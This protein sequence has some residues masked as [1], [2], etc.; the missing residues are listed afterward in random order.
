MKL[1][2]YQSEAID[3]IMAYWRVGGGNPL[4]ELATGTG[5]SLV[6]VAL[7]RRLLDGFPDM[8]VLMLVHVRE[9]VAQNA[10]ALLRVWPDAPLGIYSA[11]LGR[12]DTHR[13]IIFG[14]IQSLFR[15][16]G[17]SLGHRD[18]VLID[19][20]HLVPSAGNGM[21]RTLLDNLRRT[22]PDLRVAGFTATP[23][24]LD[25][26]RLDAGADRIFDRTVYSYD[27]GDGIRDGFLSPLVSRASVTEIDV[28]GV[29]RRGGEFV[30]GQLEKAA[31]RI[32]HQAVRETVAYGQDRR[33]WL[34]FCSGVDHAYHVR[35]AV[36]GHG[37]SCETI[38]G[39]TPSGERD[40]IVRRFRAG[41]IRCLTNAQVLTTGFDAPHVDM[42]VF[43]R[44]TLSTSLYVQIVGRGTRIA[45]GKTDCLVL[46][47]GGNI[48]RHGPVDAVSIAPKS[49]SADTGKVDVDSVRA[50]ECPDCLSLA[51][52]NASTCK[53]CGHEWPRA[54]K[55][56]HEAQAESQVGILSTE[57]V[58]PRMVPVVDWRLDRHEKLGSPDSVRVT[59]LAGLTEI[60][61][62]LAFEHAGYARQKACQWWSLHGGKTPFPT[63]VGEALARA[64]ELAMP[65]TISVRPRGKY[66][67]IV[68]RSFGRKGEAA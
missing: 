24:R 2:P 37:I 9:L 8:R 60:R 65:V 43:L 59:Y 39:E 28:S 50:K 31:D 40:A 46:D 11:G 26:G 22:R 44:S 61:E 49:G 18:L 4:V 55:P 21:Y 67:D 29:Q 66:L 20:A 48:R 30:A 52:L 34:L 17:H 53:V 42:V 35:D 36:R 3:A 10:Q 56:R 14:S 63:S 1:R 23:Y 7:T 38:T 19:E 47:F 15:Q 6:I 13:R 25:S 57:R 41:Q 16:D 64:G 27:I 58:P 62:W 45:P 51:A 54:E 33:A 32:T 5:K 68:N 12:R